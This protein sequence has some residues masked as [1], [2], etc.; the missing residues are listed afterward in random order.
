MGLDS[1]AMIIEWVAR[2]QRLDVV[3]TADT[4]AER[5]ETYAFLPIFQQWMDDHG[6]EHHVVRYVPKRFKHWPPYF[7]IL[8]NCLTNATL[9]S[10]SFG[11]HSCSLKWK[12]Q[13]QDKWMSAWPPAKAV[14]KRGERVIKLI[15]YDSS[16]ADTR[17]YAQRVGAACDP[18][19]QFRYP[20]REWGWD[21]TRCAARIRAE[22]LPVPLK[23]SCF[24]C[25]AMK[26]DEI[27]SLPAWSL[28]LIVRI[29][30]RAASRLRT[31]EG[32]WRRSTATRPGTMTAFIR[33]RGLLDHCDID[34]IIARAPA[35]LVEFQ[36][37]AAA[38]PTDER[39]P[40]GDW[41]ERFNTAVT[42]GQLEAK[43]V[44]P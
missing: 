38:L 6:I 19:Y 32:L 5:P 26:P 7:T 37:A 11:R 28:R 17:R 43:E 27:L 3:L 44:C 36:R 4:G 33:D 12:V 10:I 30:A 35:D 31:V 23:S 20:L 34:S 9:P 14:W 15:G 39:P 16:P 40:L 25:T 1:T 21:R 18:L 29:E 8:E 22:G 2:G 24:I 42:V 41:L 13:P